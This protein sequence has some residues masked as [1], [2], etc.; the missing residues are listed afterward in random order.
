MAPQVHKYPIK[1]THPTSSQTPLT[2]L[3][4]PASPQ[5]IKRDLIL[6]PKC[7]YV[8]GREKVKK[9]PEKGQVQE[10]LKKKVEIQAVRGVALRCLYPQRA[11]CAFPAAIPPLLVLQIASQNCFLGLTPGCSGLIPGSVLKDSTWRD[12]RDGD[13]QKPDCPDAKQVPIPGTHLPLL[14]PSTRQDD[15]FVLQE[16]S[17][18]SFLESIFKTEFLSLLC[19]RFEEAMRRPLTLT[20]SDTYA[21]PRAWAG[22][23]L[24]RCNLQAGAG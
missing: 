11:P 17:A 12:S 19:K 2:I 1:H 21:H 5:P 15:F 9:G 14:A 8:I 10:V 18:D 13:P 7:I 24:G 6:T 16:D 4:G 20:F 23:P 22:A 3:S